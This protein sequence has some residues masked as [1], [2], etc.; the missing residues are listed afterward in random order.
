MHAAMKR[1]S[2][3][4][5][6]VLV[7]VIVTVGAVLWRLTLPKSI[8]VVVKMMHTGP[9]TWYSCVVKRPVTGSMY[10]ARR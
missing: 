5:L 3:R 9:S 7:V 6:I 2:L 10:L 4:T 1:P 8:A